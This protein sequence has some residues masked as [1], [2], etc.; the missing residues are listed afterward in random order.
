VTG[1]RLTTYPEG[2]ALFDLKTFVGVQVGA[3]L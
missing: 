1:T 2:V 3:A